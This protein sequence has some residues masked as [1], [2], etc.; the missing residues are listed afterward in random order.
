MARIG[1]YRPN[2]PF[3]FRTPVPRT[4]LAE[5]IGSA[6]ADA[7]V[8]ASRMDSPA[9]AG[10]SSGAAIVTAVRNQTAAVTG[11]M[12]GAIETF[13]TQV[14]YA[15]VDGSTTLIVT[16]AVVR[17]DLADVAGSATAVGIVLGAIPKPTR[18]IQRA[19]RGRY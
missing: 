4:Y 2:V 17:D 5:Q 11:V 15:A 16:T 8:T 18:W 13:A 12:T 9:L 7:I 1:R 6:S 10:E 19:P 3:L 14:S